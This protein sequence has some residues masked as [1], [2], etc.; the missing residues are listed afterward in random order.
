MRKLPILVLSILSA[1]ALAAEDSAHH[2]HH[3]I[4]DHH[5]HGM[6]DMHEHAHSSTAGKPGNPDKVSQTIEITMNDQMRFIPDQISVK[7]GEI[8]KFSMK[9]AGKIP[10]EMVI[11]TM[12]ELKEHAEMMHRMPDMKHDEP[13]A[14][15]LAGGESGSLVWQF[16]KPG[17]V[18]FACLIPGHM[19]AG[20][21]GKIEVK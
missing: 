12:D 19:E 11:G 17:T 9:N 2:G 15:S 20:M 14:I 21:V 5:H 18:D 1:F 16:G 8:V 6:E 10:H 3:D 4:E 7:S 13:N